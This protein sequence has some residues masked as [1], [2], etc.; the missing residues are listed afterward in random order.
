[1]KQRYEKS[2]RPIYEG[3]YEADILNEIDEYCDHNH[4][5]DSSFY[6]SVRIQFDTFGKMSNKQ[7]NAL[8]NVYYKFNMDS[9]KT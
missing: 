9:Y 8:V 2:E 6:D 7:Y 4:G 3:D 1:M 5:F